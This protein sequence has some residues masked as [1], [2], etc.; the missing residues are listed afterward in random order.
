MM[1]THEWL[2]TQATPLLHQIQQTAFMTGIGTGELTQA[3]RDYYVAQ[4][5]YNRTSHHQ[6]IYKV[7][8]LH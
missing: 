6:K 8:P 1:T 7:F 5:H 4:D 2:T 3:Q